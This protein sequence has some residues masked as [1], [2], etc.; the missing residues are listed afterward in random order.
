LD[1]FAAYPLNL[2]PMLP[3]T[4]IFFLDPLV[5]SVILRIWALLFLLYGI[6]RVWL[7]YTGLGRLFQISVSLKILYICTLEILPWLLLI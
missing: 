1:V 3:A 4:F 7:I 5:G 2:V 6:R